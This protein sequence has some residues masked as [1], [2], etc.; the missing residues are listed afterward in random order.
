MTERLNHPW[1]LTPLAAALVASAAGIA[2]CFAGVAVVWPR[3]RGQ[4]GPNPPSALESRINFL[5]P[6]LIAALIAGV[7]FAVLADRRAH[8]DGNPS[9]DG[10]RTPT[11]PP[12]QPP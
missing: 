6:F 8:L 5:A 10:E 7:V 2:S 4:Y 9:P 12:L 1:L 3:Q 11:N